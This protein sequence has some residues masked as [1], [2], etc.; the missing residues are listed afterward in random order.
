[1]NPSHDPQ[2]TPARNNFQISWHNKRLEQKMSTNQDSKH[3]G[4]WLHTKIEALEDFWTRFTGSC[5]QAWFFQHSSF[6]LA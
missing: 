5:D 2:E 4:G 6:T 3:L 1:L